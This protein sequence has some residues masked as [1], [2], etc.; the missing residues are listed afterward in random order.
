MSWTSEGQFKDWSEE[1]EAN[2]HTFRGS[3]T[4]QCPAC[5]Q[6]IAAV[7]DDCPVCEFLAVQAGDKPAPGRGSW[8]YG[9]KSQLKERL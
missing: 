5:Q 6:W 7:A 3:A 2:G 9:S 1:P 8:L 4:V